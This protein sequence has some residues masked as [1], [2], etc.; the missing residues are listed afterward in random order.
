MDL[1]L[2]QGG[3]QID[4]LDLDHLFGLD[5]LYMM[6]LFLFLSGGTVEFTN[7]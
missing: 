6:G 4:F 1:N 5:L 3:K 7:Q 2:L